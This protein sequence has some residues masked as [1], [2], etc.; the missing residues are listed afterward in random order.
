MLLSLDVVTDQAELRNDVARDHHGYEDDRNGVG[1]DHHAILGDLG[2]GDA[3]HSAQP[4]VKVYDSTPDQDA[5]PD[6]DGKESRKDDSHAP[7]L[8]HDVGHAD[9]DG[10]NHGHHP[11][12]VRIVPVAHEVRHCGFAEFAQVRNHQRSEEN[13]SARPSHEE[14]RC[15]ISGGGD[16]ARHGNE[17]G[18][19]H[20]VGRGRHPVRKRRYAPACNVVFLC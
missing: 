4:G 14:F 10:A 8:P 12:G 11:G 3:F 17:S 18:C 5:L 15:P 9:E 2:V 20:P 13:E 19:G 1:E 7:H 6:F 16:S